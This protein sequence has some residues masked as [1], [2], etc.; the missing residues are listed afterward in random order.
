MPG[1]NLV[2]DFRLTRRVDFPHVI[3]TENGG[4][5]IVNSTMDSFF[6]KRCAYAK[7]SFSVFV[8]D[9]VCSFIIH[10]GV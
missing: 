3:W 9:G 4:K 2:K 6:K 7:K 1:P 8:D 5:T 10:S